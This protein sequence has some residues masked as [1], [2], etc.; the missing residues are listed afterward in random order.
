MFRVL[1]AAVESVHSILYFDA[2]TVGTHVATFAVWGVISLMVV[3]LIDRL[4]PRRTDAA[5]PAGT[6][7]CNGRTHPKR[8]A[9]DTTDAASGTAECES[10]PRWRTDATRGARTG[11][12]G[13]LPISS[14]APEATLE[15][16]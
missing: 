15:Y 14:Q 5:L 7:N 1:H 4:R 9:R 10:G 16:R 11:V 2:D 13:R 3:M 8:S 6:E 12:A